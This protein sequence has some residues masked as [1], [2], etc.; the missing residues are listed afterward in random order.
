MPAFYFRPWRRR[1]QTWRRRRRYPFRRRT[2]RIIPTRFR[3]RRWVRRKRRFIPYKRKLKKIR[4]NQWQPKT[5]NKCSIKGMLCLLTCGRGRVNHNFT[6]TSE[7]YVPVAEPGGGGWSIMQLT[8]RAL[9]DEYLHARNY[10]TKSNLGLPLVKYGGCTIKFYRS[11]TTDYIVTPQLTGPFEVTLDSYLN[12]QPYRHI[13]NKN[14]FIV[15][16]MTE[17]HKKP[18][19]KKRF[20]PPAL[21]LNKWYFTQDLYNTPLLM[22]TTSSC[23]FT[24]IY[25]PD[26]EISTNITFL[27]LNTRVF[28]NPRY[29]TYPETAYQCKYS[30]T[31]DTYLYTFGNGGDYTKLEN[32]KTLIPLF[33][34]E[35]YT[36]GKKMTNHSDL[37]NQEYWGNAFTQT[38]RHE[39]VPIFYGKKPTESEFSQKPNILP[40]TSVFQECRY[41]PFKDKGKGNKVYLKSTKDYEGSMLTLPTDPKRIITD[42]PLWLIFWGWIDWIVKSK[43]V[44]H[45]NDDYQII[46]QSP[47]IEPQLPCYVPLDKYFTHKQKEDL[48]ETDKAHWHPKT[49]FQMETL[50]QFA[51]TGPL[52]PKINKVKQIEINC[53]YKFHFKWGGCPAPMETIADPADQEKFPTTNNQLQEFE[54]ENP[55]SEKAHYLYGFDQRGYELTKRA[56]KRLRTDFEFTNYFTEYGPKDIALPL[57]AQ[58]TQETETTKESQEKLLKKLQLVREYNLQLKQRID[59]LSKR[60]KLFPLQ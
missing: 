27:S 28:Q 9:Y 48:T 26:T 57:Q 47:Y 35:K 43:P 45:L 59:R 36:E 58:E 34:M 1:W 22:L 16:R 49:E 54:I 31:L 14:S 41:N 24:Q 33:N 39:D 30:G 8:V 2:R 55:E 51:K 12:T 18:F 20:H 5:I 19:V 6:L 4:L 38:Y 56:A 53:F 7:S 50:E 44:F 52:S 15:T 23:D 10:W 37:D 3:R 21:M 25:A 60:Q 40:I 13:M 11:Y 17:K 29:E 42:L 46:I 32:W